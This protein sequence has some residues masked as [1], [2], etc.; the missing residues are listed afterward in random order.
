MTE[1]DYDSRI[2]ENR[3]AVTGYQQEIGK[4]EEE[5][6]ELKTFRTE[7]GDFQGVLHDTASRAESQIN[8][9]TG[10]TGAVISAVSRNFFAKVLTAVRGEEYASADSG[11]TASRDRIDEKITE[12]QDMIGQKQNAIS[13][14]NAGIASLENGKAQYL[15]EKA[16]EAAKAETAGEGA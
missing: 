14:C 6:R 16:A 12:L 2:E 5:I 7:L 10:L 11:L 15:A 8:G 4:L 3:Q 9:I 13:A 1:A